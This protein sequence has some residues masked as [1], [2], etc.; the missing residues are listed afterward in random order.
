MKRSTV[1]F[2]FLLL[3]G[4]L[5][6]LAWRYLTPI[7]F[8]REQLDTSDAGNAQ[9]L[10]IGGDNFLGYWFMTSPEMRVQALRKG[11]RINFS[12]DGGAYAVRLRKFAQKEYDCI[13]LPVNS[14]L[15]Q[16]SKVDFP[17]VIVAAISE[18]K[19]ADGIV[20]FADRLP[21]G[22]INDLNDPGLSIVYTGESPSAFLLDLTIAD[23]DLDRLRDS[24]SWRVPVESTGQVLQRAKKGQGDAF[25]LWEPDLSRA[26]ALPGMKY[27]WGSDKF[28]GYI[29]DVF[30]FHRDFLKRHP[31]TV[32]NFLE[33]YF[34]V[35]ALYANNRERMLKEMARSTDLSQSLLEN[36]LD[37]LE[38]YDLSENSRMQFGIAAKAGQEVRDGIVNTIIA[39]TDV[40][41]RTG[42]LER[43]PLGGDPYLITNSRVLEDLSRN[44][45]LTLGTGAT[46][47]ASFEA[48]PEEAWRA[49][50]EIG[51]FRVEPITFQ[52]W[53]NLLT[54]EGK[55]KV[56]KIA[57][58]LNNNYP[59]YRIVIRGHTGP[60]G[61]ERENE[62]LSLARAE[63]VRQYMVAVHSVNANRL[64]AEGVGSKFPAE[65]K[66]GESPRAYQYRLP[67]VELI[68]V[69]E[70]R[71]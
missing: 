5:G 22:K 3:I 66:P 61:D 27:V 28:S 12:D 45:A 10:R 29:V 64:L 65:R 40:L 62:K 23:F 15:E 51:T 21:S 34:R 13:V 9:Q 38:W 68:A 30:V 69:E 49:L 54:D 32:S 37:K 2:L 55:T 71:L 46:H 57:N 44:T 43:D 1:G 24:E 67:R 70:N 11:I 7:L 33:T 60:G 56:D 20:G 26:L 48:L 50:N 31:D 18:S 58:L 41:L 59:G 35:M 4:A 19:G 47:D 14:Y 63:A 42:K 6:I 39:C 36:L 16:G 52:T 17:G 53:N 25:V 8:K